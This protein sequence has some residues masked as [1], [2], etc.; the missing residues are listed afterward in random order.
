LDVSAGSHLVGMMG[1]TDDDPALESNEFLEFSSQVDAVVEMFGPTDQTQPMGWLQR[2]LPS[3]LFGIGS[4]T[5]ERFWGTL[6]FTNQHHL[7]V[8]KEAR[9]ISSDRLIQL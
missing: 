6:L 7:L 2:P 4:P 3:S 8:K 5:D 1:L 9:F